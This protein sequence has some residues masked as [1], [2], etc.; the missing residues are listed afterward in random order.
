MRRR[1]TIPAVALMFLAT[2][3]GAQP[4]PT[5]A[6]EPAAEPADPVAA[7]PVDPA[8]G[9]VIAPDDATRRA[10]ILLRIGDRVLTVGD[11]EDE[12]SDESIPP[13]VRAAFAAPERIAAEFDRRAERIALAAW[14]QREGMDRRPDIARERRRLLQGLTLQRE[15]VERLSP[16]A[17]TDAEVQAYYD[18]HQEMYHAPEMVSAGLILLAD[19]TAAR[20]ALERALAARGNRPELVKVV[21]QLSI[22]DESKRR[23]GNL[24]NF[25]RQG[26]LHRALGGSA[27]RVDPAVAA[28]AFTLAEPYDVYRQVVP[29]A[30]GPAVVFLVNRTAE[31]HRTI[32]E[33]GDRIRLRLIDERREARRVAFVNQARERHGVRVTEA[34]FEHVV[35]APAPPM[36]MEDPGA[37]MPGPGDPIRP[38]PGPLLTPN[39]RI[40]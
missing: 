22:D 33:V 8:A 1:Y 13:P 6:A 40:R 18:A 12:L 37:G 24:G 2:Q 38:I 3:A 36:P 28:A 29:T 11:F 5:T 10:K 23:G 9:P 25:D 35:V 19:E 34:A 7:E 30:R 21:R 39:T 16:D 14:A 15:V 32:E 31:Q 17:I 4:E 20:N 26:N 27:P